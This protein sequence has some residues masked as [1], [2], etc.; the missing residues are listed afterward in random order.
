VRH[1]QCGRG[2][3]SAF[4]RDARRFFFGSGRQGKIVIFA[5]DGSDA[6]AIR[7]L[8]ELENPGEQGFI[9]MKP[10]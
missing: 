7:L 3:S 5:V 4:P 10:S 9:N 1:K 2:T 8:R 6:R